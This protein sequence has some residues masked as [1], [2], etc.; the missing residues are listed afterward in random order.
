[1]RMLL[2][3][4]GTTLPDARRGPAGFCVVHDGARI[5]VDGGS[6]S[7]Y[8]LARFGIDARSLDGGVYSHR[9]LDHTGELPSLLFTFKV[10]GRARPYPIWAGQ[11]FAEHLAHLHAAWPGWLG[12]DRAPALVHELRLDGPD[13]APLPGGLRLDTR[14]ANH[15]HGA[16]HLAFTAPDGHRIVFS[17]DTGPSPAL[18][19]L[20]AGADLLVSECAVPGPDE[21]NSH[22]WPEAL[23]EIVAA[24][25]PKRLVLTHFYP[26]AD[27]AR[28]LRILRRTGV[29]TRR[30]R[31][32]DW[33]E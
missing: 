3:G 24:A 16:L 28:A 15:G 8:R 21:W 11:G 17:G 9:H 25:R 12:T 7:A 33:V 31:D 29:P 4:T 13:Q 1:M 18:A 30:G 27:P 2:V 14:P 6:G 19:E 5:L 22:L 32:G 20:A 10:S 26:E 23:A